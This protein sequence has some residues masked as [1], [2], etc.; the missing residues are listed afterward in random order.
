LWQ[1]VRQLLADFAAEV[2]RVREAFEAV[3][4]EL[5]AEVTSGV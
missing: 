5:D 1:L 2:V 4:E 3:A